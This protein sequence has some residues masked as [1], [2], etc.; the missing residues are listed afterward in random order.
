MF[1]IITERFRQ[2]AQNSA[3]LKKKIG[4]KRKKVLVYLY[5]CKWQK[6]NSSPGVHSRSSVTGAVSRRWLHGMGSVGSGLG[7]CRVE[8]QHFL[9]GSVMS[10][11]ISPSEPSMLHN[12]FK[13]F[14]LLSVFIFDT[15]QF[16]CGVKF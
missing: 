14:Q 11:G 12:I 4:E 7:T 8:G 10:L 15:T 6:Q 13:G 2:G 16:Y 9:D 1:D 5:C 3:K